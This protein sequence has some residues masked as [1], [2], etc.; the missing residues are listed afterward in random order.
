MSIIKSL[1]L[2]LYTSLSITALMAQSPV[3]WSYKVAQTDIKGEQLLIIE[4]NIA[5]GWSTYSQFLKS[6]DGPIATTIAFEKGSNYELIGKVEEAGDIK[7]AF[8][9]IFG[10]EVIKMQ[11]KCTFT[12]RVRVLNPAMPI[13]G[14]LEYMVCD[15]EQC[16]PPKDVHFSFQPLASK[17]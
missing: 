6:D 16:L 2:F 3:T 5:D 14:N 7:T 8:D 11:H 1:L 4:A 12:Q 17:I 10:M 15:S 13:T 9:A